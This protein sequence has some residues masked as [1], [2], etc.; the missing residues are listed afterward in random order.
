MDS[1]QEVVITGCQYR[2]LSLCRLSIQNSLSKRQDPQVWDAAEELPGRLDRHHGPERLY[3]YIYIYKYIYVCICILKMSGCSEYIYICIYIY[4]CTHICFYM[5]IYIYEYTFQKA[6]PA[7]VKCSRRSF[8]YIYIYIYVYMFMC[9]HAFLYIYIYKYVFQKAKP[10]GV[11]CSRRAIRTSRSSSWTSKAS[12]RC[13]LL[14]PRRTSY[15]STPN[16]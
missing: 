2:T 9:I 10:A 13:P 14:W 1:D 6:R 12:H 11:G 16:P 4:T 3:I 8:I 7:G 15:A 5:Y